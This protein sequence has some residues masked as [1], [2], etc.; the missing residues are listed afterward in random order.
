MVAVMILLISHYVYADDSSTPKEFLRNE[1]NVAISRIEKMKTLYEDN[2]EEISQELDEAK[3]YYHFHRNVRMASMGTFVAG[4]WAIGAGGLAGVEFAG[5]IAIGL[6]S[7][8]IVGGVAGWG[9][10]FQFVSDLIK[11]ESFSSE[12]KDKMS[13]EEKNVLREQLDKYTRVSDS[14]LENASEMAVRHDA[15]LKKYDHVGFSHYVRNLFNHENWRLTKLE[16]EYLLFQRAWTENVVREFRE[17]QRAL[18][19]VL[20][21][22]D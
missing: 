4:T 16:M 13:D 20:K 18:D 1:I 7:F 10:I 9:G 15:L 5:G 19:Q 14:L 11:S 2:L 17:K 6:K 3:Q 8:A 12:K 22:L 21:I